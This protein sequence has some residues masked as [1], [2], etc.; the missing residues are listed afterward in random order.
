MKPENS[1]PFC[2]PGRFLRI[3]SAK[4]DF[5]WGIALKFY[6]KRLEP[7][8]GYIARQLRSGKLERDQGESG[9]IKDAEI[10]NVVDS[11]SQICYIIDCLVFVSEHL[12]ADKQI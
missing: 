7:K 3:K 1:I 8:I 9:E 10:Q 5:G 2:S 6:K 12:T 4:L 11:K